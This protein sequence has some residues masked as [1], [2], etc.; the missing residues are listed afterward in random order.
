M[1]WS[2]QPRD[3]NSLQIL[4][5]GDLVHINDPRFLIAQKP[6]DNVSNKVFKIKIKYEELFKDWELRVTGVKRYDSGDY[7]CQAT[8]HPPS[9]ISTSLSVVGNCFLYQHQYILQI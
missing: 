5:I 3:E 1:T 8:S 6:Q 9:F 2:R 4:S 7:H